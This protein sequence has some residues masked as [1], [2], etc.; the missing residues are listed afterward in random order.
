[1]RVAP[2]TPPTVGFQ[3][4]RGL[5]VY[6]GQLPPVWGGPGGSRRERGKPGPYR[7]VFRLRHILRNR[8][9]GEDTSPERR[10]KPHVTVV[11]LPSR[12][13]KAT[14][15]ARRLLTHS[16]KRVTTPAAGIR[17]RETEISFDS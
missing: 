11:T 12:S 14:P 7:P 6:W 15:G 8:A 4:R 10:R 13:R 2:S 9:T 17:L 5:C 16:G 1:M 3:S